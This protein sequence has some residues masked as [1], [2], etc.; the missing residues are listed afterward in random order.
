MMISELNALRFRGAGCSFVFT[1]LFVLMEERREMASGK[2][3]LRVR[4]TSASFFGLD[5][6]EM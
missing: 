1:C 6:Y 2:Q 3:H 5:V 4:D